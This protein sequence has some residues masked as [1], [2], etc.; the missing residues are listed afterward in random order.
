MGP[1]GGVSAEPVTHDTYRIKARGNAFIE[2]S[3]LQDYVLLKAAETVT[4]VG[5]RYF[6][7][8]GSQDLSERTI[9]TV[10]KP[11][12]DTLVQIVPRPGQGVFDAKEIIAVIGPRVPRAS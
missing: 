6:A 8:I 11:G 12:A 2:S 10:Y 3:Q 4:S 7:I 1:L 5:G 9:D